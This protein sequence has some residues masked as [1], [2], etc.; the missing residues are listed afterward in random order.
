MFLLSRP[1]R[2]IE[3][4]AHSQSAW[5]R[6]STSRWVLSSSQRYS[7]VRHSSVVV[8]FRA[9]SLRLSYRR[10]SKYEGGIVLFMFSIGLALLSHL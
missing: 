3:L 5:L 9:L 2:D 1:V 6:C 4:R 8:L 10:L 7:L